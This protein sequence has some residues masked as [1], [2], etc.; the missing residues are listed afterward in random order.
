M[1]PFITAPE[2]YRSPY[3]QSVRSGTLS[4]VQ[5]STPRQQS[6]SSSSPS[7]PRRQPNSSS[8][9]LRSSPSADQHT[10]TTPV[11][12]PSIMQSRSRSTA[13]NVVTTVNVVTTTSSDTCTSLTTSTA[14]SVWSTANSHVEHAA[15]MPQRQGTTA[16]HNEGRSA[17]PVLAPVP[18]P[19]SRNTPLP[20]SCD[21]VAAAD[22]RDGQ[23]ASHT[24]NASLQSPSS[25]RSRHSSWSR[26]SVSSFT[27]DIMSELDAIE[28][29]AI[30]DHATAESPP[31]QYPVDRDGH[32]RGNAE[33][34]LPPRVAEYLRVCL[35]SIYDVAADNRQDIHATAAMHREVAEALNFEPEVWTR[36]F[37]DSGLSGGQAVQL[38]RI[39][40]ADPLMAN[41]LRLAGLS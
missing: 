41:S 1:Y 6:S 18:A 22:I 30:I 3:Q 12:S 5:P 37:E 31:P 21:R 34:Y 36:K 9:A 25:T 14:P 40:L 17:A 10:R 38:E 35:R 23:A 32:S 28:R 16:E 2:P 4:R 39:L 11:S 15:A 29:Q 24:A 33:G 7:T 13:A 8:S 20:P 19:N 26:L 27:S